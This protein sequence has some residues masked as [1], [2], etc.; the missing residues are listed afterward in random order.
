M[1]LTEKARLKMS[2][3]IPIEVVVDRILVVR[4]KR[5]VLDRDLADLYGVS[6]KRLNEQVRRNQKRFPEDFMFRLT[7]TEKAE[8]VAICDH[9]SPL[10]YSSSCP[11]AFTEHGAIMVASVLNS[12]RAIET[13]VFVVRA[14]VSIRNMTAMHKDMAIKLLE[15]E[16]HL[17]RHDEQFK[18][19]FDAIKQLLSDEE[20]PKKKIGFTVKE[21]QKGFDRGRKDPNNI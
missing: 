3:L 5:V 16:K 19:V 9:L 21:K 12:P 4:G 18:I 17:E 14:F 15:I 8:V 6:T 13:S 1:P 2:N 10:K 20:R 7:V 11:F